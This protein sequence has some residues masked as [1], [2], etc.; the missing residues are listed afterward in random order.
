MVVLETA[1]PA[2]FA[3]TMVEALGVEPARPTAHVGIENRAQRFVRMPA[4]LTQLKALIV[5]R[6]G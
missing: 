6:C 2:K 1:Q 3:Q 4:D 5:Q